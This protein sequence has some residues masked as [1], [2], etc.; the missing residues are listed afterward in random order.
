[1]Q[2]ITFKLARGENL[3]ITPNGYIRTDKLLGFLLKYFA[4]SSH[5]VQKFSSA[6]YKHTKADMKNEYY[7]LLLITN[8]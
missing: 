6:L 3:I 8:G 4:S 1:M 7:F 2:Y 5:A